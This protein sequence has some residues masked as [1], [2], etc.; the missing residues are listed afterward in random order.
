M[1]KEVAQNKKHKAYKQNKTRMMI[2][3]TSIYIY[4]LGE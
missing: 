1:P 4:K 3:K 2:N